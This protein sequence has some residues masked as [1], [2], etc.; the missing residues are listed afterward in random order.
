MTEYKPAHPKPGKA[1]KSAKIKNRPRIHDIKKP[2]SKACVRCNILKGTE[3][4][5]HYE[6]FRKHSLGKGTGIK[7]HDNFTAWL[8]QECTDIMDK[9]PVKVKLSKENTVEY[10]QS[11]WDEYRHSEEWL[12]LICKTHLV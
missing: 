7:C 9:K 6:G 12:F 5:A 3:R 1:K 2:D 8:C 11:L 4:L 10:W